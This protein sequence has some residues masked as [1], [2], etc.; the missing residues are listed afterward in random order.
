[1]LDSTTRYKIEPAVNI[2]EPTF[3]TSIVN[4]GLAANTYKYITSDSDQ[5]IL[6]VPTD[7]GETWAYSS[8]A[9]ATWTNSA[10]A[11]GTT[12]T[13]TG[14]V[15]TGQQFIVTA[16]TD[17]R[18]TFSS[19]SLT[20]FS[21]GTS[22]SGNYLGV[23][24]DGAGNVILTMD[25]NEVSYSSNHGSSYTTVT[26]IAGLPAYGNNKFIIVADNGDVAYS[27]DAGANWTTTSSALTAST[28]TSVVYGDGKFVAIGSNNLVAYSHDGV[29]WYENTIVDVDTFDT[30]SYGAGV[31]VAT[32]NSNK[33]AKSQDGK[34]WKIFNKDSTTYALDDTRVW[35]NLEYMPLAKNWIAV[36]NGATWN[37]VE[38]GATAFARVNVS[39]SR[40][41]DFIIYNPGS[42]YSSEPL[43]SV[44]DPEATIDVSI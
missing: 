25:D 42:N 40:I 41:Q 32:G 24:T 6:V 19:G 17:T 43:I 44:Y 23:A 4:T 28:W 1:M 11:L 33:F 9:G 3:S 22:P 21:S 29:T 39:S 10:S 18:Y 26:A 13:A 36:A 27:T 38:L 37:T 35:G 31:F 14:A 2:A 16:D 7:L 34:I 30:L 15:W 12:E 20:A 5:K 8:D